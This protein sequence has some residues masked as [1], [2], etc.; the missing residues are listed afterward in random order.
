MTWSGF[1]AVGMGGAIGCWMRWGLGIALNPLFSNILLGTLAA[2]LVG[3]YLIGVAVEYFVHHD[4]IPPELRL[5]VIV[6]FLGGLTTF[7]SFSSE[8]VELLTDR[9]LVMTFVLV[10]VHL[11]GSLA[12]TYLGMMTVKWVQA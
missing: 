7:S 5:F 11:I 12:M 10:A 6:G 3:G 4:S 8:V 9:Q 2:N 1:F